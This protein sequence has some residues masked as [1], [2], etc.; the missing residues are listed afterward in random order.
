MEKRL[1]KV[2][3]QPCGGKGIIR[4]GDGLFFLPSTEQGW[5]EH[6]CSR[7]MGKKYNF[8]QVGGITK[9]RGGQLGTQRVMN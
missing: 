1:I 7:C 8:Y 6:L 4:V 5:T 9:I 2:E 3:C